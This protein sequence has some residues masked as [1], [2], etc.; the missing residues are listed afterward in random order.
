MH[1]FCH[2]S[3]K[4]LSQIFLF[5]WFIAQKRHNILIEGYFTYRANILSKFLQYNLYI[6]MCRFYDNES[7]L[8]QPRISSS[9]DDSL[10]EYLH[11]LDD[12]FHLIRLK[13]HIKGK[14]HYTL[15]Q[16]VK[17]FCLWITYYIFVFRAQFVIHW[18]K[19]ST[20]LS[21]SGH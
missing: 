12:F 15:W 13:I 8:L 21:D 17:I 1:E 20:L 16:S 10:A 7:F 5:W 18:Q 4:I 3:S 14:L 6:F 9:Q 2:E 19:K 11:V